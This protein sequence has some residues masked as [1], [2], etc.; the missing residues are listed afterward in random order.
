MRSSATRSDS[1]KSVST[2]RFS[3]RSGCALG[4]LG[5]AERALDGGDDEGRDFAGVDVATDGAVLSAALERLGERLD[6]RLE[7]DGDAA[8]EALVERR[9]LLREVVERT[10]Q[11]DLVH[12]PLVAELVGDDL[13]HHLDAGDRIA[14]V[15]GEWAGPAGEGEVL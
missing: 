12:Q 10:A 6:P 13:E 2:S 14:G 3:R 1:R 8:A 7:D 15:G 11:F 5:E 9:H 4:V